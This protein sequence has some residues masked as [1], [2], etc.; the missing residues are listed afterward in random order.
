MEVWIGSQMIY[1]YMFLF[2]QNICSMYGI[3][4]ISAI[5]LGKYSI[6]LARLGFFG[7]NY[8]HPS[9]VFRFFPLPGMENRKNL[10]SHGGIYCKG[11]NPPMP[12]NPG[13]K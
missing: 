2:I 1:I 6:H 3:V 8:S 9:R 10:T 4:Q 11:T 13:R 5:H 7:A 12:G